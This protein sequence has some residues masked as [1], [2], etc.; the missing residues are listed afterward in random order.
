M[1]IQ[2]LYDG[3][4]YNKII[5]RYI[6]TFLRFGSKTA[7]VELYSHVY[8][9]RNNISIVTLKAKKSYPVTHCLFSRKFKTFV[10][11]FYRFPDLWDCSWPDL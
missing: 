6:Y 10:L 8:H 3:I 11:S 4:D 2:N 7:V 9:H 5:I 1:Y